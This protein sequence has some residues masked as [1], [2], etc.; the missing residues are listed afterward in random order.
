M[1]RRMLLLLLLL[2]LLL[3]VLLENEDVGDGGVPRQFLSV[4]GNSI[5]VACYFQFPK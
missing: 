2:L 3:M 1:M 5:D 4:F